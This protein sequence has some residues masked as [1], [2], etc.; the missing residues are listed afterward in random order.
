MQMLMGGEKVEQRMQQVE[1]RAPPPIPSVA[2]RGEW[3]MGKV[4]DVY[5]HCAEPGDSYLGRVLAGLN[6]LSPDFNALPPHFDIES[7][8]EDE[9]I[10]EALELMYGP[11][12]LNW[13]N[14]PQNPS[15]LLLRLLASVVYNFD[16]IQSIARA[17][18]GY[19]FN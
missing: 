3:S 11:I 12:L 15:G 7:P 6:P 17:S 19:P 8:F 1:Q 9:D 13:R 16:W 18:T 2:R 14:T 4:L 10:A 5:W